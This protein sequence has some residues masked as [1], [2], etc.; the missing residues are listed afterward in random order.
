MQATTLEVGKPLTGDLDIDAEIRRIGPSFTVKGMFFS[1]LV[2]GL[3]PGAWDALVPRLAAP[4]RHGRYVAFRDYPQSDYLRLAV[5]LAGH[6]FP[7]AGLREAMRRLGRQDFDVFGSSTFGKVLLAV[8]R[9]AR[10]ALL[11]VPLVYDKVA[12]GEYRM[13]GSALDDRTVR[14]QLDNYHH[15]WAYLVGQL[16]GT[17]LHYGVEPEILVL[18]PSPGV[19]HF[20]VRHGG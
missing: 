18:E 3:P 4:P 2:D 10:G 5:T 7:G 1:S 15:D 17:V 12:P 13:S 6:R 11:K 14:I 16:E 19:W 20:D 9:D 8:V